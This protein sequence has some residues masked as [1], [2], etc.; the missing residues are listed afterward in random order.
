MEVSPSQQFLQWHRFQKMGKTLSKTTLENNSR[1]FMHKEQR[2]DGGKNTCT[3]CS[4]TEEM[5]PVT[6]TPIS[7]YPRCLVGWSLEKPMNCHGGFSTL[8]NSKIFYVRYTCTT[9]LYNRLKH[10][11]SKGKGRAQMSVLLRTSSLASPPLPTTTPQACWQNMNKD[12]G[13]GSR[14]FIFQLHC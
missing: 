8:F 7:I 2:A 12:L 6:S 10:S 14:V 1:V 13:V 4:R 5:D 3:S 11:Y 9:S